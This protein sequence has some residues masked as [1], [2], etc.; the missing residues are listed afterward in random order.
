MDQNRIYPWPLSNCKIS[1]FFEGFFKILDFQNLFFRIIS[2]QFLAE[3]KCGTNVELEMYGI[4]NDCV[5]RKHKTKTSVG[6]TN[7][8]WTDEPFRFQKV[9][10]QHSPYKP[11]IAVARPT[12]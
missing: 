11:S 5:R 1:P 6:S 8:V 12:A 7:P 4:A 9:R 10:K 3:R 2:G